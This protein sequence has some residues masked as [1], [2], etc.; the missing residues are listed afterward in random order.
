[1]PE[2]LRPDEPHDEAEMLLPWYATGQLDSAD[3]AR[4]DAHLAGCARCQR[5]LAAEQLLIEEYQAISPEV[6]SSWARLRG[7]IEGPARA[8]PPLGAMLEE[9]WAL[10]SRPA[11]ATLAV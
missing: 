2:T 7:R 9:L 3:R 8:R 5:Q 4:V 10:L 11:I 6:D 1:M